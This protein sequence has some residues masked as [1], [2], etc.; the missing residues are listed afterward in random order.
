[1]RHE[2]GSEYLKGVVGFVGELV[3]GEEK[4]GT[5]HERQIYCTACD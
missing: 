4:S 1:M 5:P 3:M 2:G